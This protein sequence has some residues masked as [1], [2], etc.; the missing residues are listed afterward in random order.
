MKCDGCDGCFTKSHR[1]RDLRIS[2]ETRHSRHS[3]ASFPTQGHSEQP[4]GTGKKIG[5]RTIHFRIG[6]GIA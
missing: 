3:A 1:N 4:I 6:R 5:A 2:G